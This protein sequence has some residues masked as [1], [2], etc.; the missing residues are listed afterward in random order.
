ML[1]CAALVPAAALVPQV[2]DVWFVLALG[3]VAVRRTWRG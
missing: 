1:V 2:G 3:M